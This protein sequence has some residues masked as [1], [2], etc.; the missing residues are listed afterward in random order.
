MKARDLMHREV[1]VVH[2]DTPV[3][4]IAALL[5]ERRISGVPVVDGSGSLVGIVTEADLMW[6]SE[7]DA[8]H[9]LGWWEALFGGRTMMAS[10]FVKTHGTRAADIMTASVVTVD[11]DTSLEEVLQ[12]F[13]RNR[14]KRVPVTRDGRLV[15]ILSRSDFLR[16]LAL[17]GRARP[18]AGQQTDDG[19]RADLVRMLEREPWADLS[20][21]NVVVEDGVVRYSGLVHSEAERKALEIAAR[22]LPGVKAVE[23]ELATPSTLLP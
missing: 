5:L 22:S 20:T 15:G 7:I 17:A 6:R 19:L 2:P 9:R 1:A 23:M 21:V 16:A 10:D 13:D 8:V 3:N 4:E 18:P 14:I 12:V 11:E